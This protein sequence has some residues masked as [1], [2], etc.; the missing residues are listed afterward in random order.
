M[1]KIIDITFHAN[2]EY[3][4]TVSLINAQR[5]SLI[6][7]DHFP[8]SARVEVIKHYTNKNMH[9]TEHPR[10]RFFKA[11]NWYGYLSFKTVVHIKKQ[12]ADLLLIEG[13]IFP[14]QV[15]I[16]KFLL[17][18]RIKF[19][20]KHQAENPAA[21]IKKMF[22]SWADR[23]MDAYLF[24]SFGNASGWLDK[25]IIAHAGKIFE[26]PAT[27]TAFSKKDKTISKEKTG[28]LDGLHY[29]WVGRLNSNKD[30]LTVLNAF[31]IF[32]AENKATL[33]LVFQN[34][35]LLN[36]VKDTIA[37]S[38]TLRNSVKLHGFIPYNQ[39]ESWYSAADFYIS[40]SHHEGGCTAILEAMACGCIPVV[41]NIP[42][43]IKMIGN[44]QFGLSFT[45]G[46]ADSLRKQLVSS[47]RIN[48]ADFSAKVEKHF[49]V[50]Y[51]ARAVAEQ[52]FSVCETVLAK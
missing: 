32:A 4:D 36:E 37:A 27:I 35:D 50:E 34:N 44:G 49:A 20:A 39:L 11:K 14:V 5:S 2:T 43:S 22:Q 7:I 51:S 26:I 24:T 31:K 16:L 17:G 29:L 30:P 1:F 28:M 21:G 45:A 15:I 38:D 6:Y 47:T 9:M 18:K 33:H 40:A 19:L 3:S 52:M 48:Y 23:Y 41:S 10:Y 13:L 8:V 12:K 46:N 25:N 42:A